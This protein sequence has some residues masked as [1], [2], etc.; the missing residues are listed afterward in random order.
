VKASSVVGSRGVG[1]AK[2]V[3]GVKQHVLVDSAGILVPR[4]SRRP[5]CKTGPHS[6]SCCAGPNGSHRDHQPRVGRHG[7]HR[8]DVNAAVDKPGVTVDVVCRQKPDREL[9]HPT[10]RWAVE[11]TSGWVNHC[12]RTDRN[13]ETT[14]QTHKAF[15]HINQIALLLA[16]LDRSQLFDTL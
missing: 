8:S 6:P 15:A 7:L 5:T 12:R 2:K 13:D 4:S 14:L 1:G 10:R 16:R 3:D 11:R 9:H